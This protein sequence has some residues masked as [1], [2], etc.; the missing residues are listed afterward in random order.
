MNAL[1]EKES[2]LGSKKEEGVLVLSHDNCFQQHFYDQP[3][4]HRRLETGET[5]T[6]SARKNNL[7]FFSAIAIFL[8]KQK[9]VTVVSVF[10][11]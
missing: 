4:N 6:S 2:M 5:F 7:L 9:Q 3:Y 10:F 1:V 8:G 11:V